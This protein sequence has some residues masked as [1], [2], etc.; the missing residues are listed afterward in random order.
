MVDSMNF[1]RAIAIL[2]KLTDDSTKFDR[3]ID[4]MSK[5]TDDGTKFDRKIHKNPPNAPPMESHQCTET[6][7]GVRN[8]RLLHIQQVKTRTINSSNKTHT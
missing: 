5:L 6:A 1:D 4:I 2:S 3:T 8:K 7:L